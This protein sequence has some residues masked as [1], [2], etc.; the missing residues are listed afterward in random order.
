MIGRC[1]EPNHIV[2][3][4]YGGRGIKVCDA[5]LNSF[6]AFYADMGDKPTPKHQVDRIDN[7]GDYEPSNCEWITATANIRKSSHTKLN[8]QQ[9]KEIRWMRRELHLTLKQ[10]ADNYGIGTTTV[11]NVV[12]RNTWKDVA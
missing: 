2:Y 6:D 3:H 1:T 11:H 7:D 5:W 10:I 8:P 9:V 4:N 12:K